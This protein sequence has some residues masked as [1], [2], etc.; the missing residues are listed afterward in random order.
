MLVFVILILL[1]TTLY[2][3][4]P[5]PASAWYD[6]SYAYRQPFSFTHDAAISSERSI[7]FSLDTAELITAGAMQADCDD[8]RFTDINGKLLRF[9]LTGT[10]NDAATTYEVVFPQIFNG[11]N[12]GYVYYGNPSAVSASVDVSS[13]TALTPSGGDPAITTRTN[14]E[15]A[16]SPALYLAFDEGTGSFTKDSTSNQNNAGIVGASWQTQKLCLSGNCLFYDGVDDRSIAT[17]SASIDFD[18]G[19]ST[20]FT[21]QGWVR[22][23]SDGENSVGQIFNKG[24]TTYLRT[25]NE[26][27]GG[28]A[29]LE[30]S[31][32]LTGGNDATITITDGIELNK[33]THI[34]MSYTDDTDD[35]ITIYING[36]NRGTSTTGTG[37]DPASD[38]S[39]LT[40]GGPS[41]AHFHG[42]IDEFKIYHY[43]RTADQIKTDVSKV[44]SVHG[45]SA[46]IGDDQSFLSDGLM[47]YWKLDDGVND[48]CSYGV[49][50]ACD[51]SGNNNTGTWFGS[52]P[53]HWES[54][55]YGGSAYFNSSNSDY[56]NAGDMP[57]LTST[58]TLTL[59]AWFK[60]N[61]AN[62][63]QLITKSNGGF[64]NMVGLQGWNNG[65]MNFV[66]TNGDS[67]SY[68]YVTLDD[69]D[70]H[71]VVLVY[72]GYF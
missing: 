56:I 41:G 57:E 31:L 16:P 32:D 54:G 4:R 38:T 64:T 35:E 59:S 24:S 12:T 52:S 44:P 50:K 34:S 53:N 43:E 21:I 19:L 62:D 20:G 1:P 30:A 3:L 22:V 37:T 39:D 17:N 33:W 6:D 11:T 40:I 63:Y 72:D 13:V 2:F 67:E 46:S 14:E 36:I 25:T 9:Q 66:V 42:S 61:S 29:D 7:T 69:T 26:G 60:R 5:T 28:K 51:S 49:D 15:K 48:P 68:G 10:C 23:N 71:H 70:W 8:T 58:S 27:A 47:G 45:T 55:K 65:T 18:Q